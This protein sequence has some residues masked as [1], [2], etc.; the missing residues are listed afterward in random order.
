MT[1]IAT[2]PSA[3]AAA[4]AP[5][6]FRFGWRY[7]RQRRED[8]TEVSEQVPLTLDDVLHPKEGDEIPENTVQ[9]RDRN[10]L[11]A[12]FSSRR[13]NRPNLAVFSDLLIDWGV[14]GLGNHSPD[15][16]VFD[17][18][19]DPRRRRGILRVRV[20]GARSLLVVEIVSPDPYDRQARDND[21]VT[22]VDH[23]FRAGVPLYVIVDQ[24]RQDGP[25]SLLGYRHAPGGYVRMPLDDRGRLLLEPL[26][27]LLGLRDEQVVCSDAATGE[28]LPD[29][30]DMSQ[31]WKSD[32]AAR[33][34]AE[35][36]A[37]QQR[38]KAQAAEEEAAR[39]RL[40]IQV[41]K[42]EIIVEQARVQYAKQEAAL[43]RARRQMA[44]E[45]AT[46]ERARAQIIQE[47]AVL[48]GLHAQIAQQEA[49][50]IRAQLEERIRELEAKLQ[51]GA[52]PSPDPGSAN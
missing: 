5:N 41:A 12:V 25:R 20:E 27:V 39:Q 2:P 19:P 40:Q 45:E 26:G 48:E 6:P 51:P 10:Y 49:A 13:T 14:E 24:E 47:E 8:G 7:V 52:G 21:V 18:V 17:Q 30:S 44:Q 3:P 31:A 35:E 33:Q 1:A 50:L 4:A 16:S 43:E 29:Y 46:L 28:E 38:S 36:E 9:A 37:A 34:L 15:I 22:K 42:Q 11:Q 32:Q 23:Y